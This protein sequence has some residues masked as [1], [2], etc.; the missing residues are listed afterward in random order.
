MTAYPSAGEFPQLRKFTLTS[1][2]HVGASRRER[3]AFFDFEG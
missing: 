1:L 3:T 2:F